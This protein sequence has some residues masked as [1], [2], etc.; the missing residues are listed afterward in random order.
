MRERRGETLAEHTWGTQQK[1]SLVRSSA[2]H[3][4]N[5][6]SRREV[7]R[8]QKARIDFLR[9]GRSA[10]E[11]RA[12]FLA[13]QT[14][15]RLR[16]EAA[17]CPVVFCTIL[18]FGT[19]LNFGRLDCFSRRTFTIMKLRNKRYC[20]FSAQEREKEKTLLWDIMR[21]SI[22][23]DLYALSFSLHHDTR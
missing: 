3:S 13:W 11:S 6:Y 2:Y 9:R 22:L 21:F 17:N 23:H 16:T 4:E 7:S 1:L 19:T 5:E 10:A 20:V 8:W 18:R 14:V 12:P 15:G